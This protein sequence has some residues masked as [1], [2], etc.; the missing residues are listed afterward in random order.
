MGSF[1]RRKVSVLETAACETRLHSDVITE[2]LTVLF[3]CIHKIRR[4]DGV[5][6]STGQFKSFV[7]VVVMYSGV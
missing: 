7:T 3:I 1:D 4:I 2:G 5:M 6:C